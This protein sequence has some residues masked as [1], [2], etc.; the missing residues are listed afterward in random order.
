MQRTLQAASAA[1]ILGLLFA[2]SAGAQSVAVDLNA[3]LAKM[4]Y[5]WWGEL[6]SADDSTITVKLPLQ[7]LVTKYTDNFKPGDRIVLTWGVREKG[8]AD[9]VVYVAPYDVMKGAKIDFGYI[10]PAQF[11]SA[12]APGRTVTVKT[13]ASAATLA[14]VKSLAPGKTIKVT[15]PM[16]QPSETA[17]ITA[18]DASERPAPASATADAPRPKA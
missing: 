12:D 2:S 4:T 16:L 7:E 3:S 6:V 8:V 10:L 15:M 11:V 13:A 1:I 18:I 17:S 14:V 9:I 5:T